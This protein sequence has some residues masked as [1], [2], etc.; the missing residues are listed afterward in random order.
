MARQNFRNHRKFKRLVVML[1]LPAVHVRGHVEYL[2]EAAYENGDEVIG[3][4]T[5]VEIAAEWTGEAGTLTRAL[6]ECGG[7][8][9]GLIEPTGDGRFM[10]HDLF[11]HA[12]EFVVKRR[13]RENERREKGKQLTDE[14]L[15]EDVDRVQTSADN[16]GQRRTTADDVQ[17][18]A[19]NGGFRQPSPP[20]LSL[21]PSPAPAPI[22]NTPPP[23]SSEGGESET[24]SS[25]PSEPKAEPPA[26]KPKGDD[27][28]AVRIYDHYQAAIAPG[29]PP[30]RRDALSNIANLL[31]RLRAEK[32]YA[33]KSPDELMLYLLAVIDR[34]K[35]S[36]AY[37]RTSDPFHRYAARNFFG[38][39]EQW[40]SFA[41][42]DSPAMKV[43]PDEKPTQRS[44][45]S[46]EQVEADRCSKRPGNQGC[47]SGREPICAYCPNK[48]A[49]HSSGLPDWT[50]RAS[51]RRTAR[52]RDD[53]ELLELM[54]GDFEVIKG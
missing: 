9:P 31:K 52:G 35:R 2:W 41:W 40:R 1:G 36:A 47:I 16:G 48:S 24:S 43:I 15:K 7:A 34:Y 17:T 53:E 33:E 14:E 10:I 22:T 8:G 13:K 32:A 50:G 5:D 42:D 23:P 11:D 12:P 21:S 30:A 20:A 18:S 6:L 4:G 19:D 54:L 27:P 25:S 39:A 38:R 28:R 49:S 29:H 46:P 3:D 44:R 37:L 51:P 45:K 26:K